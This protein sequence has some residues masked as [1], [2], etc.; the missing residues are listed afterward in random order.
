MDTDNQLIL[1]ILKGNT[2][3]YSHLMAKYHNEIYMYVFNIIGD[4]NYS[5]DV[6]QE[7]FIR[8]YKKLKYFDSNKAS[9][10]TWLYK[11]SYNYTINYLKSWNRRKSIEYI[12]D[13]KDIIASNE[14]IEENII[15]DEQ[16]IVVLK[17]IDKVL[18]QKAKKIIYLHYFSNLSPKEISE[19]SG[20]PVQTVYKSIQASLEKIRNEV[21]PNGK[22]E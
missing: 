13:Q 12:S 16:V 3:E 2:N 5:D 6:V 8:I 11:V 19:V 1:N 18:K 22:N 10:R 20:F 7:I 9:F 4:V 14:N 17:A 21:I 15:K